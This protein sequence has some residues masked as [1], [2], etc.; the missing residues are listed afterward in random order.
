VLQEIEEYKGGVIV[1]SL[2]NFVFDQRKAG[3]R[4]S[5]IFKARLSRHGVDEFSTLPIEIR[6]FQPRPVEGEDR[7]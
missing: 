4:K 3:T 6:D 1:Y 5:V 2:G 7:Q